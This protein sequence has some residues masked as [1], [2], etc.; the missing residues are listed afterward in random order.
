M[1]T[2]QLNLVCEFAFALIDV[3]TG[4][5]LSVCPTLV[6]FFFPFQKDNFAANID[7]E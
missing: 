6:T 7:Q 3:L 2:S 5:S 4:V 1:E